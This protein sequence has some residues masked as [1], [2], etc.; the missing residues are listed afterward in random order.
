MR[1]LMGI[2]V[3]V[4]AL[5]GIGASVSHYLVEPYNPGFVEYRT[6]TASHVVLGAVFLALAPFQFVRPI[7]ARW[8]GYH[9]RVGRFLVAIGAVIGL[10][11]LFIVLVFPTAGNPQR[12][13][14]LP[15]GLFFLYA[16]GRGV[17]AVRA[18]RIADHREWMIRAFALGLSIATMR[19]ISVPAMI[20]IG[21]PTDRQI[22]FFAV[23]SFAVAILL[24]AAAAE[25]WIRRTRGPAP[26]RGGHRPRPLDPA[27]PPLWLAS[28]QETSSRR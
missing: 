4:L 27:A 20:V 24:H 10:A 7:R 6:V 1:W 13:V 23:G 28:A 5:I 9:R 21:N 15:F 14:I 25:I 17:V 18:R 2:V 19:V 26:E 22:A 8:P 3:G 11:G 12:A 16:L